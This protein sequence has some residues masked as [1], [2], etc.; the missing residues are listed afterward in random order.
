[1]KTLAPAGLSPSHCTEQL[2]RFFPAADPVQIRAVVS[3]LRSGSQQ[4]SESVI[5]EFASPE[6]AIFSSSLP[7]EFGDR[8]QLKDA[9]GNGAVVATV[10]AVQYH[11]AGKAIAVQFADG[12]CSWVQRP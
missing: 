2:A 3:S 7:L 10:I 4:P 11:E 12:K 8:I 9:R 5:V 6:R 1:M